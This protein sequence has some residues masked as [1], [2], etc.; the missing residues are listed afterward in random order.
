MCVCVLEQSTDALEKSS[1]SDTL[2]AVMIDHLTTDIHIYEHVCLN[3]RD[4][5][6][7]RLIQ[8]PATFN[9]STA[10]LRAIDPCLVDIRLSPSD[11]SQTERAPR[12]P[13]ARQKRGES[14][15]SAGGNALVSSSSNESS[16]SFDRRSGENFADESNDD[17]IDEQIEKFSR[18]SAASTRPVTLLAKKVLPKKI[19]RRTD[20][21]SSTDPTPDPHPAPDDATPTHESGNALKKSLAS[22]SDRKGSP[23]RVTITSKLNP[24]AIPFY[25][26][27][28]N[29]PAMHNPSFTFYERPRFRPRLPTV[30]S[31][32]RTNTLPN[33]RNTTNTDS[34][35]QP[36]SPQ[37]LIPLRQ[38]TGRKNF[39]QMNPP[40]TN[41][42][43]IRPTA[44]PP[45]AAKYRFHPS[46]SLSKRS[47]PQQPPP[48]PKPKLSSS[49]PTSGRS[50]SASRAIS[51][52]S[53]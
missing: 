15:G 26:Q 30:T 3:V 10:K 6:E 9:E 11:G 13:I 37:K 23:V 4:I 38:M 24:D 17:S 44:P 18:L 1:T 41:A 5:L 2:N 48:Q 42:K 46:T 21:S 16:S 51:I 27:Q 50:S 25:A 12:A 22:S 49:L 19:E 14:L 40:R 31:P 47:Y 32:D 8:L 43:P 7:L 45:T 33:G 52:V 20:A 39:P 28:R 35:Q 34:N 53:F 29:L 36:N